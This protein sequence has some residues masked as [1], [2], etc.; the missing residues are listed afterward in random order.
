MY[1]AAVFLTLHIPACC[2]FLP[3]RGSVFWRNTELHRISLRQ[4]GWREFWVVLYSL[5]DRW[6]CWTSAGWNNRW[7]FTLGKTGFLLLLWIRSRYVKIMGFI[8]HQRIHQN[9]GK[10]YICC[11]GMYISFSPTVMGNIKCLSLCQFCF[12]VVDCLLW[13]DILTRFG[14]FSIPHFKYRSILLLPILCAKIHGKVNVVYIY[15]CVSIR[16]GRPVG[17]NL[18]SSCLHPSSMCLGLTSQ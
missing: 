10:L 2:Q 9:I 13:T 6:T 18:P 8:C 7:E 14:F 15:V 3:W 1:F 17:C 5:A 11:V 4:F 16:P 12:W